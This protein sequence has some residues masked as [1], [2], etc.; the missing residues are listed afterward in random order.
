MSG[1]DCNFCSDFPRLTDVRA[2]ALTGILALGILTNDHPVESI[3]GKVG[4]GRDRAAEHAGRPD[5]CILLEALANGK[6]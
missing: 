6:T 1:K 3:R 2:S 5:V 4:K